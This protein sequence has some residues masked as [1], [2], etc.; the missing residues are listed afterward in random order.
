MKQKIRWS[1]F[2]GLRYPSKRAWN[3]L[4]K[5]NHQSWARFVGYLSPTNSD[6]RTRDTRIMGNY[7]SLNQSL[8]PT[9]RAW[10]VLKKMQTWKK[11]TFY[12]CL[13][14][15]SEELMQWV[16]IVQL[17]ENM[18]G[19]SLRLEFFRNQW[20]NKGSHHNWSVGIS[21]AWFRSFPRRD[22]NH[23]SYCFLQSWKISYLPSDPPLRI[24]PK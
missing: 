3:T 24:I 8:K 4:T 18:K 11:R 21:W 15:Y 6:Q 7:E 17:P 13:C 10:T 19:K 22:F 5:P 2:V 1:K 12:C 16:G 14:L 23:F 9:S 20:V